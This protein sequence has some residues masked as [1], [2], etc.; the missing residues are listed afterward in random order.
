MPN[1][2]ILEVENLHSWY[3]QQHVLDGINLSVRPGEIMVILGSSGCGKT[4][5]LKNI[6]RLY[7]PNTGSIRL[8]G[9]EMTELEEEVEDVLRDVGVMYQHGALLNSLTVG[10]NVA[11]PLEMHTSI[12]PE[13]RR[14]I[15]EHKLH[16]VELVNVYDKYPKELSVGMQKRVAVAR[17]IVMDPE[18]IFCDEP[19]AGLDPVTA[20]GLDNLLITLNETLGMTIVVVTHELESIKRIAH[21]INFLHDGRILFSGSLKEAFDSDIPQI[22]EFFLQE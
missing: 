10:E 11:I 21:R 14:E 8:L 22:H 9:N 12:S 2:N 5:L 15:A 20:C 17:A 13:L 4:T 19:T 1:E 18:I 7:T 16:Q 3:G 6:I